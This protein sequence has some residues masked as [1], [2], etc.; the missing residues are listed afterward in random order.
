M[1][2]SIGEWQYPIKKTGLN[3]IEPCFFKYIFIAFIILINING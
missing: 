2:R 1:W 3:F